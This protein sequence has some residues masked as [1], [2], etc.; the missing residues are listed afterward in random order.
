LA[1]GV[2]LIGVAGGCA[3][4]QSPTPSLTGVGGWVVA[5]GWG[6]AAHH[7]L[8]G[9]VPWQIS[10]ALAFTACLAVLAGVWVGDRMGGVGVAVAMYLAAACVSYHAMGVLKTLS[11]SLLSMGGLSAGA[12]LAWLVPAA[13]AWSGVASVATVLWVLAGVACVLL[14]PLSQ[15]EGEGSHV[16]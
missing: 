5:L 9:G 4:L 10:R 11:G 14:R 3:D 7:L 16:A 13:G 2:V 12:L 1:L 6:V 8:P 15:P